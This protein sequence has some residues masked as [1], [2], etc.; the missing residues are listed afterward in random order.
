[1]LY[2]FECVSDVYRD[3]AELQT[4]WK[5]GYSYWLEENPETTYLEYLSNNYY[6]DKSFIYD[7]KEGKLYKAKD[8]LAM[9]I[10]NGLIE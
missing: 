5:D 6:D 7:T 2:Y 3:D 8:Y 9:A 10:R 1:M 4:V